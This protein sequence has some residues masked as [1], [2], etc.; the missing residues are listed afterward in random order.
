MRIYRNFTQ[1]RNKNSRLPLALAIGNFDGIHLGHQHVINLTKDIAA[2]NNLNSAILTFEPHPAV[3]FNP[4]KAIDFRITT[5]AQKLK[6]FSNL[7]ISEA[8]LLPFNQQTQQISAADFV[9]EILYKALNVKHLIVGADFIFGK[10]RVGDIKLLQQKSQQFNFTL[11]EV[12]LLKSDVDIYQSYLKPEQIRSGVWG[13]PQGGADVAVREK[14]NIYSST[15][16]RKALWQGNL[17]S[18]NKFLGRNFSINGVVKKGYGLAHEKL[19][20]ATANIAAKANQIKVKFGVYKV[21]LTI[22]GENKKLPAIM[23]F[24]IKP[25]LQQDLAPLY[26]VHILDFNSDIYGKKVTIELLDFLREEKKFSSLQQLKEQITA[27]IS[28]L[29]AADFVD[30]I[31]HQSTK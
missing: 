11:T 3:F 18:A 30:E 23:N 14:Q 17:V 5:L 22:E 19:G 12:S 2:S 4:Q 16:I 27:D 25:T 10:D 7:Q 15:L 24:G 26:E 28:S 9:E 31:S 29:S 6:I 8:I 20:F 13:F 1:V 21:L